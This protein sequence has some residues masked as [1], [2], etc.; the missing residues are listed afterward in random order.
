MRTD[1]VEI[2]DDGERLSEQFARVELERGY[3]HLR[4]DRPVLGLEILPALFLQMDRDGL[5]AQLLEIECDA[6]A[7]SGGG[8][9][10][11]VELHGESLRDKCG[12]GRDQESRCGRQVSLFPAS[13][14][15]R[16][17]RSVS[18]L[19]ARSK[20]ARSPGATTSDSRQVNSSARGA[21]SS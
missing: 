17:D 9:K 8:T 18:C 1:L 5:V 4:I 19:T 3:P 16:A 21:N 2:F 7:I 11:G 20:A 13:V 10:V 12:C 14:T 15:R 6:H